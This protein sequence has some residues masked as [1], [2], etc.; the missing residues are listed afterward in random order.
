MK[1]ILE[2]VRNTSLF[3]QPQIRTKILNEGWASYWHETLFLA[4]DRICGHEVDFARVNAGVTSLPR[5]GLNPYALGMRLFYFIEEMADQGKFSREF[6]QL[7]DVEERRSFDAKTGTGRDFIFKI[8]ENHCDF[9]FLNNFLNQDFVDRHRLF[10]AGK[11]MN[12]TKMV[13][14]YYVKSRNAGQYRQMVMDGLY[15]PP[16]IVVDGEKSKDG[17]LYLR[18]VF[19]GKPLVAE[20][21]A[22][23][24]MGIEYFW[25]GPVMLETREV[26]A[27]PPSNGGVFVIGPSGTAVEEKAADKLKWQWVVYTMDQRQIS[28][29][30]L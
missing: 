20:Y 23:T 26:M 10:V 16:C 9:M 24:M 30:P 19:E 28:K 8:R 27:K 25:G 22:N 7:V 17:R 29:K 18:H 11:R 15:H 1:S 13:W 5:V 4:D 12:Q 6:E 3:F 2:I 14:E 21:I